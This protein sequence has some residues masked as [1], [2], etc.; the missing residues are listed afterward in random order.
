MSKS[1]TLPAPYG[2]VIEDVPEAAIPM[3]FCYNLV[4][5]NTTKEGVTLRNGDS[6]FDKVVNQNL[7]ASKILGKYGDTALFCIGW[8][9]STNE[10][11]IYNVETGALAYTS[12]AGGAGGFRPQF[13]NNR[14]YFFSA[15][16]AYDPG[17]VYDGSSWGVCGYTGSS[18][19]PEGGGNSFKSRNYIVQSGEAAYWYSEI[20]GVTGALTKID[21]SG[22]VSQKTTL[23]NIAS[24]TLSDQVTTERLQAFIM[25]NGEIF[26]YKGSYPDSSDW[27]IAGT[28]KIGNLVSISNSAFP[29]QGDTII[30]SDSGIVSLRD[31]FLKGSEEAINLSVN[32]RVQ[33]TW[34]FLIK[35]LRTA[36]STPTGPMIF[37]IKGVWDALNSRIYIHLPCGY[38]PFDS[39]S[40]SYGGSNIFFVYDTTRSSWYFHTSGNLDS[41]IYASDI[42]YY[43]NKVLFLAPVEDVVVIEKEGST[44][45][46]DRNRFDTDN[47]S[48]NFDIIT[49]PI[50][51]SKTAVQSITGIEPIIKSDMYAQI[52]FKLRADLGR[53]TTGAQVLADQGASVAKPLVNVGV[54]ST[55]TQLQISGSTVADK[56]VGLDLYSFNVWHDSGAEASR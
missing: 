45:F 1:T 56:T 18:F 44:G 55:F 32:K 38:T 34:Q 25:A 24:I 46:M 30:L 4:N 14:L 26:F 21:L 51:T 48:Y 16:P 6:L 52:N 35:K 17:F 15:T 31:L 9:I 12:A 54:Q 5:F 53:Q 36:T 41:P 2:G 19:L 3:P 50:P 37:A 13:F 39:S 40:F 27:A 23:A 43:K 49:A 33:K 29:Y 28:A 42:V 47:V 7:S 22:I 10:Q 20:E 11:K 8:D